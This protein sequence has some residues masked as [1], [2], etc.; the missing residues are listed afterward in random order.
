MLVF[1]IFDK[2]SAGLIMNSRPLWYNEILLMKYFTSLLCDLKPGSEYKKSKLKSSLPPPPPLSRSNAYL[3]VGGPRGD[4]CQYFMLHPHPHYMR[5]HKWSTFK[6]YPQQFFLQKIHE[7]YQKNPQI[8][9]CWQCSTVNTAHFNLRARKKDINDPMYVHLILYVHLCT[10]K[11]PLYV[12]VR[13]CC[14]RYSDI[15]HKKCWF[16]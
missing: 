9:V 6:H 10:F 2:H 8:L 11:L 3:R 16:Y 12:A 4:W 5:T 13:T 1:L 15:L 7:Y 14:R